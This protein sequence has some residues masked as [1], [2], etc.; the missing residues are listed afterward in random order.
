MPGATTAATAT[1]APAVAPAVTTAS[2]GARPNAPVVVTA[3]QA[4]WVEV[5]DAQ[6]RTLVSRT[7][8]AG[9]SLGVDGA[10]PMKVKIGN[11][12]G[13]TVTLRGQNVDLAPWVRDNVARLQLK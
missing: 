5:V 12:Q 1:P 8:A 3:R 9:E 2:A 13:T 10:L 4:S 6:G 11:A 7:V